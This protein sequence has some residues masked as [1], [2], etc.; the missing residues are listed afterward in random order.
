VIATLSR[1]GISPIDSPIAGSA[2]A[3]IVESRFCIN[4]ARDDQGVD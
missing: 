2:V 3:M 1:S 4:I